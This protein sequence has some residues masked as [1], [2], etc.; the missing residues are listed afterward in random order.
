MFLQLPKK[1][2]IKVPKDISVF[3]FDA[4]KVL[5]LKNKSKQKLYNSKFKLIFDK[6]RQLLFVSNFFA[7]SDF[8]SNKQLKVLKGIA[9]TNIKQQI[10]EISV[11]L[12]IK[13]KLVGVGYKVFL[14]NTNNYSILQFKLGFSHNLYFLVNKK[15]EVFYL[16]AINLFFLSDNYQS[17]FKFSAQIQKMKKFDVYKGKGILNSNKIISLKKT[18]SLK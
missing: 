15:I 10:L 16:K 7:L 6:K 3:Y 8:L 5:I 1:N 9:L 17:L 12:H 4:F 18:K 2:C 14:I 13:L 11:L